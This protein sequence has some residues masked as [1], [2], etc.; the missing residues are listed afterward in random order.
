M[1]NV[2]TGGTAE[3]VE[4]E[5]NDTPET[6]SPIALPCA[7]N[8]RFDVA[9]DRDYYQFEAK[10]GQRWILASETAQPRARPAICSCESSRPMAANWPKSKTPAGTTACSI[11]PRRPMASIG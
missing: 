2:A 10:A 3:Q 6:A 7:I 1:L 11:S 5:P 9:K 8:G 4:L